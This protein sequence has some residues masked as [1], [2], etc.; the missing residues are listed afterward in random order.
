MGRCLGED[1]LFYCQ[2]S[3]QIDMRGF[4]RLMA[5]PECDHC[6]IDARLQ[7]LH[8]GGMSKYMGRHTH[9]SPHFIGVMLEL[10]SHSQ[11]VFR[12]RLLSKHLAKSPDE[13]A[14]SLFWHFR[15]QPEVQASLTEQRMGAILDRVRFK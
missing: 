7:Q 15:Y 5:Q 3:L 8:G 4:N 1:L 14:Q 13:G 12:S 11:D 2:I 6:R 9:K 10:L